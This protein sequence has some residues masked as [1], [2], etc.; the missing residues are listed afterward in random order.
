VQV[1]VISSTYLANL[2]AFLTVDLIHSSVNS[3]TDLWGQSIATF[4]AYQSRLE[5]NYHVVADI[6]YGA[7]LAVH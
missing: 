1:L 5:V 3:I 4:P 6:S 7:P 2:A